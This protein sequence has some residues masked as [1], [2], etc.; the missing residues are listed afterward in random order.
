MIVRFF[1]FKNYPALCKRRGYATSGEGV[2]RS[3]FMHGYGWMVGDE[4]QLAME[5]APLFLDFLSCRMSGSCGLLL[6]FFHTCA[7]RVFII[8]YNSNEII[9]S[10][11][12]GHLYTS[13]YPWWTIG[14]KSI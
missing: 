4:C 8:I 10:K 9:I 7:G 14:L 11:D 3:L 2:C 13:P 12:L 5:C 6:Y 1:S